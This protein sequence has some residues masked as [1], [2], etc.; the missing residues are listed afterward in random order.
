MLYVLAVLLSVHPPSRV[1][2]LWPNGPWFLGS[3]ERSLERAIEIITLHREKE[4]DDGDIAT[5]IDTLAMVCK[6]STANEFKDPQ[7]NFHYS[8]SVLMDVFFG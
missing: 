6:N 8:F 3:A 1:R 2:V 4:N 5:T 7:S